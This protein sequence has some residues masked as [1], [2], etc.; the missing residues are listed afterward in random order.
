MMCPGKVNL[1]FLLPAA[2]C[3]PSALLRNPLDRV[4]Q[5]ADIR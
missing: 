5:S 1:F 4:L 3:L 2:G